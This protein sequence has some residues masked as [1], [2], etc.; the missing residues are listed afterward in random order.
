DKARDMARNSYVDDA[1]V[2]L[3]DPGFGNA[4]PDTKDATPAGDSPF[5]VAPL[6][7]LNSHDNSW[8][9]TSFGLE[10]TLT[11]DD[12]RFGDRSRFFKLQ[13]FAI[14]LLSCRGVPMLWEGEE[15]A[16]NYAI[17]G[18]GALRISFLRGMHW[19]YFYDN[20]GSP[21]VRVYR[22]MGKLRRALPALR[23]RDCFY[24]NIQSRPADGLVA[25]QRRASVGQGQQIA[26]V[27]LNFSDQDRTLTLRAPVS[28]TYREMLDRLN[29]GGAEL[30]LVAASA[31]DPL[32]ISVP[33]N[34]GRIFVT[35]PPGPG[36][37]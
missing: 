5:P 32:A 25:F 16:E 6:Q 29:R 1:F 21:L 9:V 22:R 13:P 28:G 31:N 14:A 18:G 2:L 23:S 17:A 27:V 34:Y 24:F 3:L 8:L 30:D 4:Y 11:P 19:E 15:F 12:I 35:P 7:Y 37:I 33:S 26:L 36:V 10:P 20:D